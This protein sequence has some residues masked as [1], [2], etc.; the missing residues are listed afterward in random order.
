MV[1]MEE[2]Q[3]VVAL[4]EHGIRQAINPDVQPPRPFASEAEAQAWQ[5]GMLASIARTEAQTREAREA[6]EH[7]RL[8]GHLYIELAAEQ[9]AAPVGSPVAI[10]ATLKN[11][12]GEI[13]P[14]AVQ[15]AVPVL[16]AEGAVAMI[17]GVSFVDGVAAVSMTFPR[18]GYY[19]ITEE[20]INRKLPPAARMRLP[21]PFE[22][23][24]FE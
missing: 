3:Y 23:T 16:D 5:D 13:V 7:A 1:T 15:F 2:G 10:T 24:I 4:P 8:A 11:G 19:R 6:E 18:S 20:G 14:L 21:E 9:L 22:I 17:K 12:L